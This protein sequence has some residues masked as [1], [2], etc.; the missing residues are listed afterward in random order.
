MLI[1]EGCLTIMISATKAGPGTALI[2]D[3]LRPTQLHGS[4][5]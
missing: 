4:V 3:S 5:V 2:I 1:A